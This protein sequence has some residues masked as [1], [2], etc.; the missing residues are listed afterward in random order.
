LNLEALYRG[1]I[2]FFICML[3]AFSSNSQTVSFKCNTTKLHKNDFLSISITF[4]KDAKKEYKGY[5]G[6]NFPDVA[7]MVK[8]HTYYREKEDGE[9]TFT[10]IQWY[11]PLKSGTMY[12]PAIS[13]Q[14]KNKQF[15]NPAFTITVLNTLSEKPIEPPAENWLGKTKLQLE[16]P[17]IEWHLTTNTREVYPT[18]PIHI[19]GFVLIPFTNST[20]FSFVDSHEQ[21]ELLKKKIKN[22]NCLIQEKPMPSEFKTDTVIIDKTKF[23]KL[24][25]IDQFIFPQKPGTIALPETE[26]Y[27]YV[28]KKGSNDEGIARLP[29]KYTIKDNGITIKVKALPSSTSSRLVPVGNFHIKDFLEEKRI[30]NG[31]A[32]YLTIVLEGN[33]DPT[34]IG[35]FEFTSSD[36]ELMGEE[37]VSQK[38]IEADGQWKI[39]KEF[40]FQINPIRSGQYQ[41][42]NA[43]RYVYFNSTKNQ[44]DTL[45]PKSSLNVYGERVSESNAMLTNDEFY[46][47][48]TSQ[49]NNKLFL[50]KNNDLFNHL[51]N[52]I[53]LVMLAVTA[54]LVIKK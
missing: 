28:Y 37:I 18:Q 13:I 17:E 45:Y 1:S 6:Y 12:I 20:P 26:W 49:T 51:A 10:I 22:S 33:S 2:A 35:K 54:I 5:K 52:L 7:D 11:E 4:S 25:V 23:L 40:K 16:T 53:I 46:N 14:T 38:E 34:S 32:T 30:R 8:S 19:V 31:H 41:M 24:T 21:K 48:Y 15:T 9:K 29:E 27:V 3:L 43:F 47:R 39:R 44:F 42:S 36:I 50:T